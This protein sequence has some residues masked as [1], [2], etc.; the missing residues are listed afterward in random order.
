MKGNRKWY[1]PKEGYQKKSLGITKRRWKDERGVIRVTYPRAR[2]RLSLC[3]SPLAPAAAPPRVSLFAAGLLVRQH[4]VTIC[5][6]WC[7]S[8][9]SVLP[10]ETL[11]LPAPK[12]QII[13]LRALILDVSEIDRTLAYACLLCKFALKWQSPK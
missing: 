3:K 1:R 2:N 6:S 8:D 7:D 9:K 12:K 13:Y 11:S 10:A 4:T 5:Y